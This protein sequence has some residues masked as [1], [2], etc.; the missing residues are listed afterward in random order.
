MAPFQTVV[1]IDDDSISN[2]I[3]EKLILREAF[4]QEVQCFTSAEKALAFFKRIIPENNIFPDMIFLDLN[5]PGMDGWEF[6]KAYKTLP[7]AYTAHCRLFMLSSA[8]DAKDIIQAKSL[9]E[10]EDFISKPLTAEDIA[11]IL[12]KVKYGKEWENQ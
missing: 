6:I 3:T 8:V 1:L 9:D 10:V 4:A 11:V 2:F 7:A 12:E 5:M